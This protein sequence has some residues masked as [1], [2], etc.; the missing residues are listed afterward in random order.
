MPNTKIHW[1]KTPEEF[2]PWVDAWN[3]LLSRS[4]TPPTAFHDP[5]WILGCWSCPRNRIAVGLIT[6]DEILRVGLV[7]NAEYDAGHAL[8]IPIRVLGFTPHISAAYPARLV[9][10]ADDHPP[11]EITRLIDQALHH[12]QWQVMYLHVN[13]PSTVWLETAV[14][15]TATAKG[16]RIRP[17]EA[18]TDAFLDT[19]GGSAGYLANRANRA[20]QFRGNQRRARNQLLALGELTAVEVARTSTPIAEIEAELIDNFERCWQ[21]DSIHSPLHPTMRQHLFRLLEGMREAG[22]LRVYFLRLNG[23]AIAF[24]FGF[25]DRHAGGLY[26]V[27]ARGYD[28]AWKRQSPGNL[29]TE[30]TI[31]DTTAA[32]LRGIYLGPINLGADNSYKQTWLTTEWPV[33]TLMIIHPRS[34]YGVLDYCYEKCA[35]FRK[36]WWKFDLGQRLRRLFWFFHGPTG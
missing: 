10:V 17:G 35:T 27:C 26:Y 34:I 7:C 23:Q 3:D 16:W 21:R 9:A 24:E 11:A 22:L 2:A 29:L 20:N 15:A 19:T 30:F 6:A 14:L 33:R 18:S 36:I 4:L 25:V 8:L 1:L 12:F 28:D 13:R 31:D 32:G 5:A